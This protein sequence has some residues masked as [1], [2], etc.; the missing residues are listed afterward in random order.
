MN[1]ARWC[2]VLLVSLLLG[3]SGIVASI[4]YGQCGRLGCYVVTGMYCED[5]SGN[6]YCYEFENDTGRKVQGFGGP[7]NGP[8]SDPGTQ[9]YWTEWPPTCTDCGAHGSRCAES[10]DAAGGNPGTFGNYRC[11]PH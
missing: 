5:Y 3:A 9:T 4:V 2:N 10:D 8:Y 11:D 6:T 7:Q 1:R